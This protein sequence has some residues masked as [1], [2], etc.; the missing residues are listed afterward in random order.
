MGKRIAREAP[1]LP[2]SRIAERNRGPRDCNAVHA[3]D[4]QQSEQTQHQLLQR[5]IDQARTGTCV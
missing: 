1:I 4:E 5:N 2:W 3:C